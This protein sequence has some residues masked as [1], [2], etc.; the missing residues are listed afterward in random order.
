MKAVVSPRAAPTRD[1]GCFVDATLPDPGPPAGHDLLVQVEAVSVNPVDTKVRM[2]RYGGATGRGSEAIL[3]WDAAGTVAAI[4]PEVTLFRPGDAVYYAGS[5]GRPGSNAALQLVDERIVGAKPK[6]LDWADAASVPLTALTAYEAIVERLGVD[7]EGVD[8]GRSLL[9]V[10]GAGGA[11]SMAIQIGRLLGLEVIAT[12]SRPES[13]AWCRALGAAA[14]I[15][16]REPL[17]AGLKA[18]GRGEVDCVL[19][20]ADTDAYWPQLADI[21]RPQGAVCSIVRTRAPVAL[22][23]LMGKCLRFAWEAMFARSSHA[24]PDMI[25][26][27]R[28]LERVA[29]WIDAG[30]LRATATERLSPINAET[31]RAAHARVETGRMIGKIVISGWS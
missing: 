24:T 9:V 19:L 31:L 30:R 16:H 4:G 10:A 14:V 17:A 28:I 11:G 22:D 27:H 7:P 18:A 1:A 25:E 21:V 20:C 29:A 5:I 15:D 8:R 2:Q 6:R 12:A 13:A 3:G 23:A 26:Q